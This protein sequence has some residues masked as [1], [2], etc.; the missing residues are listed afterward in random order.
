MIREIYPLGGH[1][2]CNPDGKP[3]LFP[4]EKDAEKAA[5]SMNLI[6]KDVTRLYVVIPD[7]SH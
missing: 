4:S 5:N 1:T 7:H 3:I 6:K 2:V